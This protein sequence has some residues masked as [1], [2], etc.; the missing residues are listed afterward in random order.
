[1]YS[2]DGYLELQV[3]EGRHY[4]NISL[5]KLSTNLSGYTKYNGIN[6]PN[7]TGNLIKGTN[8][9]RKING[10]ILLN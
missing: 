1:V 10:T 7:V 5:I 2:F 9:I 3:G 4:Y 6:I 8:K